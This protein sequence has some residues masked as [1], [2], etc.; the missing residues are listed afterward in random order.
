MSERKLQFIE[1]TS[2]KFWHA[3]VDGVNVVVTFGRIGTNGQTQEKAFSSADEAKKQFDKQV[4]D[5]LKKGYV[6]DG[7][8]AP[9]ATATA[10]AP[11]S[12]PNAEA[13]PAAKKKPAAAAAVEHPAPVEREP[14]ASPSADEA[15]PAPTTGP[16]CARRCASA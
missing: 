9:T 3:K 5:Q 4:A 12:T 2:S 11:P 16:S 13:K 6:D 14:E 10:S 7:G 8:G 15:M 1:G